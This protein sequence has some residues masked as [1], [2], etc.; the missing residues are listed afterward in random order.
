MPSESTP[1]APRTTE[2]LLADSPVARLRDLM[3]LAAVGALMLAVLFLAVAL[4]VTHW[5]P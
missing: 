4:A 5:H 3:Q 1:R 2:S